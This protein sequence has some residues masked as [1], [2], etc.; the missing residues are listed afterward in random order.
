MKRGNK[1]KQGRHHKRNGQNIALEQYK[2]LFNVIINLN[3]NVIK[4]ALS[5]FVIF[6]AIVALVLQNIEKAP[7]II[8]LL[9]LNYAIIAVF[10]YYLG[11][12]RFRIVTMFSFVDRIEKGENFKYR[13]IPDYEEKTN[14][15][16]FS[17]KGL[18]AMI[19]IVL[20]IINTVLLFIL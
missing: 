4:S 11:Y 8:Y 20:F 6:A 12:L 10:L 17:T 2:I 5:I 3:D 1:Q 18:F 13:S 9:Y 19:S 16:F 15:R 7:E 14:L